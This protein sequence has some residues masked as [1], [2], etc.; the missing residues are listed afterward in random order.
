MDF[1]EN[2]T[3]Y[4]QARAPS[5]RSITSHA[6][7]FTGELVRQH[8]LT[9]SNKSFE[10]GATIWSELKS[11]GYDTGVFST[12]PF[13]TELNIGLSR[14]FDKTVGNQVDLLFPN[15]NDPR[16][17]RFEIIDGGVKDIYNFISQSYT[18][19]SVTK[20][21]FN[22]V[23]L[24][25]D[26]SIFGETTNSHPDRKIS[27]SFIKWVDNTSRLWAACI[28]LMGSHLPF[29]AQEQYRNW[30]S[31]DQIAEYES[32]DDEIWQFASNEGSWS[33]K[34]NHINLYDDSILQTDNDVRHILTNIQEDI[35]NT[36][37]VITSDHG[38]GFGEQ[39]EYKPIQISS[40]GEAAGL[41]EELL[42]VPLVVKYPNQTDEKCVSSL[43]SPVNFPK[44][45]RGVVNDKQRSFKQPNGWFLASSRG[46]GPKAKDRAS[47]YI[48]DFSNYAVGADKIQTDAL[49]LED[50]NK[51]IHK[52]IRYKNRYTYANC[53][54]FKDIVSID[55]K[56]I[57]GRYDSFLEKI[58]TSNMTRESEQEN[59]ASTK[60]TLRH[61]GYM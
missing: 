31:D 9:S 30:S 45:V 47:K 21:I 25:I 54:N 60:E 5:E 23:K 19:N 20:S 51:N 38:E 24:K 29:V 57:S 35:E 15:A 7:I 53:S 10:P 1:A 32:V 4:L 40:H 50:D 28:N 48:D 26:N 37:V 56:V 6:S 16:D 3:T 36:L 61:L 2:A 43:S 39:S 55:D 59:S 49:Y 8:Q 17:D 11:E 18:E 58:T 14:D 22:G 33:K 34:Q 46:I 42:H 44:V 13:L 27:N 52:M 12:N 41:N